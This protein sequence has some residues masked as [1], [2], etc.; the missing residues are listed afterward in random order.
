MPIGT[1]YTQTTTFGV[2]NG[3]TYQGQ[4]TVPAVLLGTETYRN[5]SGQILQGGGDIDLDSSGFLIANWLAMGFT[6]V[7]DPVQTGTPTPAELLAAA[8]VI[9]FEHG[10]AGGATDWTFTLGVGQAISWVV[11]P[12]L[13]VSN[14]VSIFVTPDANCDVDVYGLLL[15]SA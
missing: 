1:A 8:V 12:T 2:S 4:T 11:V 3:P 7:L 13:L 15:L 10:L 5:M 14:V 9:N 6:A